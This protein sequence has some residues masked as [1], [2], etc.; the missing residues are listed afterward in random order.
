MKNLDVILAAAGGIVIG[1][2]VGV[3]FAP[4]KGEETRSQIVDYIR[5]KAKRC[6]ARAE[7]EELAEKIE[8]E[9]ENE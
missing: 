5:K 4:K 1:A 3:L 6:K 7:L 2:A 8:A 9:L